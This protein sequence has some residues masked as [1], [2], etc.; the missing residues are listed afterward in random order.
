M[1]AT[2]NHCGY[3]FDFTGTGS[4]PNCAAGDQTPGEA[5]ETA[6]QKFNQQSKGYRE[7]G[8]AR[9]YFP[10]RMEANYYRYLLFSKRQGTVRHFEYQPAYLDFTEHGYKHG[11]TR[12]R[13]DFFVVDDTGYRYYVECKGWYDPKSKTK[14]KRARECYPEIDIRLVMT[15][16]MRELDKNIGGLVPGW[17]R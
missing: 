7:I 15:R 8:G 2:C 6:T 1:K 9:I 12:Y 5:V 10:N 14:L 13:P 11:I 3:K 4:C 16:D 17:E